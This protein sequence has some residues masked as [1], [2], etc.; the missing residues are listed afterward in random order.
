VVG[1]A[2]LAVL[3]VA[4]R[5]EPD[6]RGMGTHTQLGLPPCGWVVAFGKP[7]FTC[8]MTTAFARAAR[9]DAPGAF[10]AQPMGALLAVA[11]AGLFW[12]GVHSAATGS[13]LWRLCDA[14]L[15]PRVITGVL[16]LG[17]LAW[18]Y[19]WATWAG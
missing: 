4:A 2:A 15:R 7:C 18:A 6:A 9:G 17:G 13:R 5:L 3:I 11:A 1:L 10:R 14:L 8:G 12:A 19:K 16:V